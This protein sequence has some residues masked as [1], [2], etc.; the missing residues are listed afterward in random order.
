MLNFMAKRRRILDNIQFCVSSQGRGSLPVKISLSASPAA[1]VPACPTS[2][3]DVCHYGRQGRTR[4]S[5]ADT[6][7]PRRYR[8]AYRDAGRTSAIVASRQTSEADVPFRFLFLFIYIFFTNS[9]YT[10]R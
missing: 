7:D 3:A 8:H 5:A 1:D 10:A 6:A 4:T 9:I 2:V